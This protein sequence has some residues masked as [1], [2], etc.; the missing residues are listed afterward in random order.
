MV[1]SI[2][3]YTMY[4]SES[5]FKDALKFAPERW[6]GDEHYADDDRR[7]FEPFHVGPRDCLGKKYVSWLCIIREGSQLTYVVWHGI[8]CDS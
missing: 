5:N 1:I 3:Q 8:T 6:L 7:A 2:P 4:R